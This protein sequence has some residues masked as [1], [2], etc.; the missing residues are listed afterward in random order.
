MLVFWRTSKW[1]RDA[2]DVSVIA[3]NSR[4]RNGANMK[5]QG[6]VFFEHQRKETG[7]LLHKV[8]EDNQTIC[9]RLT[10]MPAQGDG[11]DRVVRSMNNKEVKGD[12]HHR[13]S[14]IQGPRHPCKEC[15][16]CDEDF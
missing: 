10:F 5:K 11:Y 13:V 6:L 7:P 8:G 4:N 15:F 9:K 12:L 14:A 1:V 16:G 3:G 2:T